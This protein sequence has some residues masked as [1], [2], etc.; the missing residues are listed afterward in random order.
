MAVVTVVAVVVLLGGAMAAATA[1]TKP[2]RGAA[3]LEGYTVLAASDATPTSVLLQVHSVERAA[4][5]YRLVITMGDRAGRPQFLTL[6]PGEQRS[7]LIDLRAGV[8][9]NVRADLY[10]PSD[11]LRPYRTLHLTPTS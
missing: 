10:A 7:I 6:Q 11:A 3:G 9:Q 4:Q 8:P 2:P 5:E 1:I